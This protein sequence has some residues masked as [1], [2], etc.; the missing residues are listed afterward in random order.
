MRQVTA[1]M[2]NVVRGMDSAMKSMDLEKVRLVIIMHC[3]PRRGRNP[4]FFH[5]WKNNVLLSFL[6]TP[7]KALTDLQRHG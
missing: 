1:S 4:A 6:N 7:A 5:G 3:V 2:A